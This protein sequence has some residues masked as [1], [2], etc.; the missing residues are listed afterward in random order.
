MI[1][2]SWRSLAPEK[3]VGASVRV[4]HSYYGCDSG[5]C[6]QQVVIDLAAKYDTWD[7]GFD[8][9]HDTAENKL[10]A[11]EIAATLGIER[12]EDDGNLDDC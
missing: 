11:D 8:F 4:I 7:A 3:L 1:D 12:A 10:L 9:M 5:C 6:G 2:N